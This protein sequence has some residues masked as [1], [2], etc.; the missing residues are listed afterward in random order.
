MLLVTDPG[1]EEE[2]IIRLARV[3][4][5]N[6]AGYLDGGFNSWKN[7]GE[8]IDLV[9]DIEVDELAMDILHDTNSLVV[10]VRREPEF[11]DGHVANALNL[12]LSE[13]V[14][15]AQIANFE[16]HQNLYIHCAGGYRSLIACSLLKR[17]G[18]HNLRNVTG[19]WASIKDEPRIEIARDVSVLN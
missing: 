17:Q 6:V 10:D 7:A 11:A 3:G 1:M 9:I 8:N 12:P 18:I 16:D 19:G 4:F 14:D 2:T 15:V 5:D 13:M